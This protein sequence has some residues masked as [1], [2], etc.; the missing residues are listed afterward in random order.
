M[1]DRLRRGHRCPYGRGYLR[2]GGSCNTSRLLYTY[3]GG[4]GAVVGQKKGFSSRYCRARPCGNEFR[5]CTSAIHECCDRRKKFSNYLGLLCRRTG[6][7][8]AVVGQKKGF[9]SRYCR[10]RPCGNEFRTC[11]SAIHECCDRR[12]KFSNYLGLLCR[13]TGFNFFSSTMGTIDSVK[14]ILTQSA[15]DA[16]C[17]KYYILDDVH[18]ELLGRNDRIHN[19]PTEMDL[20]AFINH[21]HPTKVQIGEREVAEGEV[22]LLQLTKGRIVPLAVVN[23]QGNG[24]H[25][26]NVG[27][28]DVVADAEVRAIVADKLQ[29]VRKKRKAAD[30]ASGSG[31][32]PKKLKEDHGTSGISANIGGKSVVALQSLLEGSTLHV[33]VY[34]PKWNVTN[35]SVLDDLDVCRV[36]IDHLAPPG[37]LSQLRDWDEVLTSSDGGR[38]KT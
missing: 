24:E 34:I 4:T 12:K 31:L 35:D 2:L 10:A 8:G 6:G 15:L 18:P 26:V 11:T 1:N 29:R 13:R 25:V 3:L 33:E 7:T 21:A 32:S 14:S 19:S 38:L 30:S 5:T 20:F 9:S 28:I 37:F 16:L 22:L 17:E 23:Y 36:M 27:G